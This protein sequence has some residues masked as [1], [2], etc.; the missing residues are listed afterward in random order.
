MG[1]AILAPVVIVVTAAIPLCLVK[2]VTPFLRLAAALTVFVN[3]LSEIVL[4]LV[5]TLVAFV[6][7]ITRLRARHAASHQQ[8]SQCGND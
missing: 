2:L 5:D 1:M 8:H 6:V 4:G 3:C 7:P